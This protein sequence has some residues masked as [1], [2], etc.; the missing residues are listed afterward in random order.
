MSSSKGD[1]SSIYADELDE[2]VLYDEFKYLKSL[3]YDETKENSKGFNKKNG[4]FYTGIK[5]NGLDQVF[6]RDESDNLSLHTIN[7][8]TKRFADREY[9]RT[10]M[11]ANINDLENPEMLGGGPKRKLSSPEIMSIEK[12]SVEM[13]NKL[14]K[15]KL[16]HI[17]KKY[18]LRVSDDKRILINRLMENNIEYEEAN[19][20][21]IKSKGQQNKRQKSKRQQNKRQKNKTQKSK[22]SKSKSSKS[23]A[24]PK[25]R[26]NTD[27]NAFELVIA[28]ILKHN[29]KDKAD[30]DNLIKINE[31]LHEDIEL[32]KAYYD[33]FKTDYFTRSEKVISKYLTNFYA[34]KNLNL[35]KLDEIER[36]ILSGKGGDK[37]EK[38]DV[39]FYYRDD[40]TKYGFSVK[41]SKAATLSNYSVNL[42][43]N[44]VTGNKALSDK[45]QGIKRSHIQMNELII[46]KKDDRAKINK[47]F[48][49]HF[50]NPYW[51]KLREVISVHSIDIAKII[52]NSVF[53][54]KSETIVYEYDGSSLSEFVPKCVLD[55][56]IQ[57]DIPY[58]RLKSGKPRQTSKMF[59]NIY[60]DGK[61]QY[62]CEIRH[63]GSWTASPQ[64][65]LF[66]I[67]D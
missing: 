20:L 39:Y 18:G 25:K 59:Y 6:Y 47:L 58:Y 30:I 28:L 17:L 45:I 27:Y 48:Y 41:Q 51:N 1:S 37:N 31:N 21:D 32:S 8:R 3:I 5:E 12:P 43:L 42:I 16:Q 44:E 24:T 50:E 46:N 60:L 62:R 35:I 15:V 7:D 10:G 65:M 38:S 52:L 63:K 4:L 9:S 67:K 34:S 55:C 26:K 22:S 57:E 33:N 11:P 61:V 36:V 14:T 54:I 49:D 40:T 2:N 23:K 64:F 53:C 66:K 13:W 56:D 29:V 19:S